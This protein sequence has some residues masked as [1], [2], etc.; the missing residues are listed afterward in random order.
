MI[1]VRTK[2]ALTGTLVFL[3]G[4]LF[5]A[6]AY[7]GSSRKTEPGYDV[8]VTFQ[9]TDGLFEG[10]AVRLSGMVVGRVTAFRL[11][12]SFRAITT[13][14]L[15]PDVKLPA[16]TAALIHSDGLLGAKYIELQPGGDEKIIRPG[17][18]IVYAQDSVDLVDLLEKIVNQAKAKRAPA[19]DP[20]P[21]P[22]GAPKP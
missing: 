14:R 6:Q 16:D 18:T 8:S 17:G 11:D 10:A 22:E 13:L 7:M 4:L 12:E 5:I 15:R 21:A 19:P 20:A 2:E 3:A 9:R 1:A